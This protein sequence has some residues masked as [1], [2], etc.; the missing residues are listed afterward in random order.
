MKRNRFLSV[1][2]VLS[3]AAV[4]A[5]ICPRQ[6]QGALLALWDMN[7]GT[8]TAVNDSV[9]SNNGAFGATSP[10]WVTGRSGLA[11]D[12][13]LQFAAYPSSNQ[14]YVRVPAAITGLAGAANYS[15][16]MWINETNTDYYGNWLTA[17]STSGGGS[18]NWVGQNGS[19]GDQQQYLGYNNGNFLSTGKNLPTNSWSQLT[20]TYDNSGG[21]TRAKI[22]LNGTQTSYNWG[23][24][25]PAHASLFIGGWAVNGSNFEGIMDDLS[26]WNETLSVG[27]AKSIYNIVLANSGALVDYT[28][29]EMKAL[30]DVFDTGTPDA[31]T[32]VAGT[33]TWSKFTGGTGTAGSVTFDGTNYYAWFDGTSGVTAPEPATL[34][35]LA[36]GGLAMLKRRRT[37]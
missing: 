4:L 15:I 34:G 11:G 16:T 35:L 3:L 8:G 19:G 24:S 2:V 13:A 9:A 12:K 37:A 18:R 31:V 27:K 5:G 14:T 20:I 22:F 25:F 29:G 7:E 1:L 28:V 23:V 32:S 33:M 26:I 36:L 17:G 6:A 10:T 21:T 30:F